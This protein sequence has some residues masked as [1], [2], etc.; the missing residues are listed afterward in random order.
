MD[1]ILANWDVGS[2]GNV[3]IIKEEG[4]KSAFRIDVGG[5]LLFRALGQKRLYDNIPTEHNSFFNPTNKGYKL[6]SNLKRNQVIHMFDL[7]EKLDLNK[8]ITLKTSLSEMVNHWNLP[9]KDKKM[10][11][12]VLESIDIVMKR[13]E[14][15]IDNKPSI[16]QFLQSQV[17]FTRKI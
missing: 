8:F 12:K 6:F 11:I 4:R 7:I 16:I 15:Y 9:H 3:G 1:C 5:S 13:H 14:Y 17:K 2:R 10:A